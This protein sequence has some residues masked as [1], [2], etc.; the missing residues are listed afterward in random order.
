MERAVDEAVGRCQLADR[1]A[2]AFVGKVPKGSDHDS[3]GPPKFD[4]LT[5]AVVLK[6]QWAHPGLRRILSY[7]VQGELSEAWRESDDIGRQE[8]VASARS[9][10]TDKRSG[11]LLYL[12]GP[13]Q[14]PCIVLPNSCRQRVFAMFHD[15]MGHLG[16]GKCYPLIAERYYWDV[17]KAMRA[18][19]AWY[20]NHCQICQR[21]K[22]LRTTPG[23]YQTDR[24][25]DHPWDIISMDEY[26]VGHALA[27][28]GRGGTFDCGDL[29]GRAISC[30]AIGA[31]TT[32]EEVAQAYVD[33]VL[34]HHGRSREVR[35]DR[36]SNLISAAV[37]QLFKRFGMILKDGSSHQH[38]VAAFVE[39]WHQTL[40]Q[41]LD[42]FRIGTG[43]KRWY[44][45]LSLLEL[46]FNATINES[47]GYSPFFINHLRHPVLPYDSLA[48]EPRD[49]PEDLPD[50][51]ERH[52]SGL[53]VARDAVSQKLRAGMLAN[54]KVYDLR[55]DVRI[56]YCV[57]DRVL[58][59]VGSKK[60]FKGVH[61]K[62]TE[63][64]KGPNEIKA[65]LSH[66]D[67]RIKDLVTGQVYPRIH[68]SLLKPSP[69]RME[70]PASGTIERCPVHGLVGRRV[71]QTPSG[72]V[73]WYKIRWSRLTSLSD[74]WRER[75]YLEPIQDLV[76]EY[77]LRDPLPPGTIVD[78]AEIEEGATF[79]TP[80]PQLAAQ[81]RP[82]FRA[83]PPSAA[84][85]PV[86][87]PPAP[88][89]SKD[90]PPLPTAPPADRKHAPTRKEL[91]ELQASWLADGARIQVL[92]P[93]E[94]E[95]HSGTVESTHLVVPRT[96]KPHRLHVT[97][98]WD[99]PD[100]PDEETWELAY[101]S[102]HTM[103]PMRTRRPAV[104]KA[105]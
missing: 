61:P 2:S 33:T 92:F 83:L 98:R 32:S 25:G 16:L 73:V 82:R 85:D 90:P 22:A 103:R 52:I 76:A 67:Y 20:I 104:E 66:D 89:T 38:K 63:F 88:S 19:T 81:N 84:H 51:V 35:C 105:L 18:E 47:T 11:L 99:A 39:R 77:E 86:V 40:Q 91:E 23:A 21:A 97:V 9:F 1:S 58:R 15:R 24:V 68:V 10:D 65:V 6:E 17:D 4:T 36:G 93:H 64:F 7:V 96:D 13:R 55:H 28:D 56:R 75:Q 94:G 100:P 80:E 26:S 74:E 78:D 59:M 3:V 72:P 8:L 27:I 29:F 31:H 53:G 43:E 70:L 69:L 44:L 30:T 54:K 34:R 50:W 14:R 101:G 42:A 102:E 71:Q 46:C 95:W 49:S 48:G 62:G 37:R 45:Y 12:K 57:G 87:E 60:E 5:E 79:E 41:L